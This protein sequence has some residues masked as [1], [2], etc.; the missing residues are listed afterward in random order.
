MLS[1]LNITAKGFFGNVYLL[2]LDNTKVRGKHCW[3]PISVMGVVDRLGHGS[4][5]FEQTQST[6]ISGYFGP[7]WLRYLVDK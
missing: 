5:R 2:A 1:P 4:Q 6:P 7:D 3:T